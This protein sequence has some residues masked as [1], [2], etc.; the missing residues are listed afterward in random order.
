MVAIRGEDE[1]FAADEDEDE[2]DV[3]P[4]TISARASMLALIKSSSGHGPASA[5]LTLVG[6]IPGRR[7][8]RMTGFTTS[9]TSV[10]KGSQ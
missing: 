6:A 7:L 10:G 1:E 3:D 8:A 5:L 9:L 2:D 4:A